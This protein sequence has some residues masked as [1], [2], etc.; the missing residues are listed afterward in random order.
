[1]RSRYGILGLVPQEPDQVPRLTAF[2]AA[3]PEVIIGAGGF[4]T[5]QARIPEENGETVI[6]RYKL[7]ELLDK[8]TELCEPAAAP[9]GDSGGLPDCAAP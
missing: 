3:H 6:T 2:R 7:E 8:L 4:G 5:W 1:M 9:E